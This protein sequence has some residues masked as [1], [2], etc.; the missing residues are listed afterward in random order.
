MYDIEISQKK[1]REVFAVHS[2]L[3][4]WVPKITIHELNVNV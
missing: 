4:I 3:K 2:R 1:D